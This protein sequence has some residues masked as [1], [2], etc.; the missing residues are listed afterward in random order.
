MISDCIL[1]PQLKFMNLF[2][3][4][5]KKGKWEEVLPRLLEEIKNYQAD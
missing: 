2:S 3:V 1:S 5:S 4:E